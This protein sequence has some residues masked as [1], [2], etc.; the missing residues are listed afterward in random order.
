[1]S[2]IALGWCDAAQDLPN[3]LILQ[4]KG[5]VRVIA[6]ADP[7]SP[8]ARLALLQRAFDAGCDLL[9]LSP[10]RLWSRAGALEQAQDCAAEITDQLAQLAGCGQLTVA[11]NLTANLPGLG[12]SGRAWLQVL[13]DQAQQAQRARAV[14]S[15]LTQG[16]ALPQS[17]PRSIPGGWSLDL[18]LP[19]VDLARVQMCLAQNCTTLPDAEGF[20]LTVTGLWPPLTFACAPE[21]LTVD[22]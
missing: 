10:Q 19:R 11:L 9:P 15:S 12:L 18:L 6:A 4:G 3:P 14:L 22:V 20:S 8:R 5:S 21:P 1:M 16:L 2:L 17:A 7:G 13:R